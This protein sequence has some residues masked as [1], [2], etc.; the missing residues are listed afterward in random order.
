M[1]FC[2]ALFQIFRSPSRLDCRK[3]TK[4][5]PCLSC[6]KDLAELNLDEAFPFGYKFIWP[7]KNHQ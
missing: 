5:E 7:A 6:Y 4:I 2:K 1:L 3:S